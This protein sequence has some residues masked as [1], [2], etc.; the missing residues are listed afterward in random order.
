MRPSLRHPGWAGLAYGAIFLALS[1]EWLGTAATSTGVGGNFADDPLIAYILGWVQTALFTRPG[2]LFHAPINYPAQL[3]LAASEHLLSTQILFAPIF[4][5][6]KNAILSAN[7]TLFLT[8]PIAALAMQRFLLAVGC[9]VLPAF[10]VG[11]AFALGP[12]QAPANLH[13]L[14]YL[15]LYLPLIALS[16][17]R[18]RESPDL[19]RAALFGLATILALLSSYYA[20]VFAA[21]G[22]GIWGLVEVSRREPSRGRFVLLAAIAAG[23]AALLVGIFS[24]PYFEYQALLRPNPEQFPTSAVENEASRR[25]LFE[26]GYLRGTDWLHVRILGAFGLACL[27][28]ASAP[29]RRC[30]IGGF[31]IVGCAWIF[32]GGGDMLLEFAGVPASRELLI[33]RIPGLGFFRYVARFAVLAGFGA[34]LVCAGI[35]QTTRER[36]GTRVSA[37]LATAL[38][39]FIVAER[40]QTMLETRPRVF[41]DGPPGLAQEIAKVVRQHGAGPLLEL[42]VLGVLTQIPD[43]AGGTEVRAMLRSLEHGA[44]LIIGHT[45]HPPRHRPVLGPSIPPKGRRSLQRLVDATGLRWILLRPASQWPQYAR[46]AR[47]TM[48]RLPQLK[49]RLSVQGWLL[50]EVALEPWSDLWIDAI[51]HG[52]DTTTTPIGTPLA[53]LH[54]VHT[55]GEL[56]AHIPQQLAASDTFE[57]TIEMSNLGEVS[58]PGVPDRSRSDTP[59]LVRVYARWYPVPPGEST[60]KTEPVGAVV[61]LG[62]QWDVAPGR[63]HGLNARLTAPP[64]PGRYQLELSLGQ[65]AGDSVVDLDVPRFRRTVEV[66]PQA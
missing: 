3:Q 57:L 44:P 18:L 21:A 66:G 60:T 52:T 13:V 35:L 53:A 40:G 29:A 27:F 63:D 62:L 5:V 12:Y 8:Y 56:T 23:T 4:V 37:I 14:Q 22:C 65:D 20:A 7:L 15:N 26:S 25:I 9:T 38:A 31:M 2:D 36:F 1:F 39:L 46:R 24:L 64:T 16:L 41:M 54:G 50:M 6:T 30:L 32:G 59:N 17:V 55:P 58:W 11:F 19:R 34:A 28:V 33:Q 49:Q 48:T 43:F 45:G 10:V 51:R 47:R 61:P 42:P